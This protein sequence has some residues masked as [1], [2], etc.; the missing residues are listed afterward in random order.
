VKIGWG[1]SGSARNAHL[2]SLG[3]NFWAEAS[4]IREK[5][6]CLLETM[7][8]VRINSSV[9]AFRTAKCGRQCSKKLLCGDG[10]GNIG[11]VDLVGRSGINGKW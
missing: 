4:R 7:V 2:R 6:A 10:L 3:G 8:N 11:A 9:Q 5:Y 1:L